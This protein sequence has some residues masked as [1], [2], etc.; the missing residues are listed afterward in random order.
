MKIIGIITKYA[1]NNRLVKK[2]LFYSFLVMLFGSCKK[3]PESPDRTD[4]LI[5]NERIYA[6]LDSFVKE[7][8]CM[9]CINELY[10]DKVTPHN[11]II[12]IYTGNRSLTQKEN[13]FN[14]Q[15][16]TAKTIVSGIEF[17]IYSGTEHYFNKNS[18]NK[19]KDVLPATKCNTAIWVVKDNFDTIEI[20]KNT[21]YI[22]P[23]VALPLNLNPTL[24]VFE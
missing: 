5:P 3:V 16:A 10:I 4:H 18:E 19:N 15:T 22:Y 14:E 8:D 9:N 20:F 23:F 1:L 6:I 11:Y 2:I 21:G 13:E 17:N 24:N 12:T 7:N